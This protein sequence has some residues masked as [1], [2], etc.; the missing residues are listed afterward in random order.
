MQ[1]YEAKG[2]KVWE[3]QSVIV[4]V[5]IDPTDETRLPG[6][7]WMDMRNRTKPARIEAELKSEYRAGMIAD[8]LNFR[9]M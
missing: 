7:T 2:N 3:G 9:G 4:T 5:W 8:Q 6:E 1:K